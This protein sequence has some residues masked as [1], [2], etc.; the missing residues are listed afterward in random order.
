MGITCKTANK[1]FSTG[2][3]CSF[4]DGGDGGGGGG[5]D[6]GGKKILILRYLHCR[7]KDLLGYLN[8][9]T[10]QLCLRATEDNDY[11]Q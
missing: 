11:L 2:E 10:F 8:S 5:A 4:T 1:Q 7:N 3:K 6:L 9:N